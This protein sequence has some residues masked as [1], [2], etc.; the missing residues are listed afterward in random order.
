MHSNTFDGCIYLSSLAIPNS[1]TDIGAASFNGIASDLAVWLPDSLTFLSSWNKGVAHWAFSKSI[2]IISKEVDPSLEDPSTP[3]I[4]Y[5]GTE[6]DAEKIQL[7][8]GFS[9]T[10]NYIEQEYWPKIDPPNYFPVY[11]KPSQYNR[12]EDIKYV[13]YSV[14]DPNKA[15]TW[16]TNSMLLDENR[17]LEIVTF[18]E[19]FYDGKTQEYFINI[20]FNKLNLLTKNQFYQVQLYF[21]D[22]AYQIAQNVEENKD[23]ISLASQTTLIRPI[24]TPTITFEQKNSDNAIINK[25]TGYLSYSDNSIIESIDTC[26]CKITWLDTRQNAKIRFETS[27]LIKNQL[28]LSFE[29][30]IDNYEAIDGNKYAVS[31]LYNT[32]NG[33]SNCWKDNFVFEM[34]AY[35]K[36]GDLIIQQELGTGA[37][38][39]ETGVSGEL[40]KKEAL[41][42]NKWQFIK[43]LNANESYYDFDID[44]EGQYQYRVIN[45]SDA[46]FVADADEFGNEIEGTIIKT[47][48]RFNDIFISDKD[49]ML[50]AK[51]NPNISGF[52]YVVQ[53]ATT[54]TLGGK[55]PIIRK[56]GDTRY[57]QFNLSGTLYMN[58]S[59]YNSGTNIENDWNDNVKAWFN[60]DNDCSLYIKDKSII[61]NYATKEKLERQARELAIAFLTNGKPKLFRSPEEGNMIVHL[62]N[63]SFTPNKQLGRAVWDFSATVTEICEYN[64][65]N[66]NKYKLN[67]G[68]EFE[69]ALEFAT[70]SQRNS[71]MSVP[72]L[73]ED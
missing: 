14:I 24:A 6:E 41:L 20:P 11:F 23:H 21:A 18:D 17:K 4:N 66:I 29:I 13:L 27:S 69:S 35:T 47:S 68:R 15:S 2:K 54:N 28:G 25:I 10:W 12:I 31:F 46:Y 22:S 64:I 57:K 26:G 30:P 72:N 39:I 71:V 55:Y 44:N 3:T 7:P 52:K 8:D 58:A 59:A 60:N 61:K 65:E 51:Y 19:I 40:Q 9:A 43:A 37:I 38:K 50:I 63:I 32:K 33:Y 42:K 56:N 45:G 1:L 16:G 48:I 5:F 62:S 34:P 73:E 36:R 53:E 49:T 67:D 70:P